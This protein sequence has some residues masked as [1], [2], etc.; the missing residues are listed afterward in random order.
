MYV[1]VTRTK[2]KEK[3]RG[4]KRCFHPYAPT[5]RWMRCRINPR[6]SVEVIL[7]SRVKSTTLCTGIIRA[8]GIGLSGTRNSPSP[9]PLRINKVAIN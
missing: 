7:V 9:D 4:A 8:A 6:N 1:S 5:I 2:N 3:K